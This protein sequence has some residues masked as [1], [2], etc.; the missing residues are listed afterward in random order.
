[1]CGFTHVPAGTGRVWVQRQR[2]RFRHYFST[3]RS[4][5]SEKAGKLWAYNGVWYRAPSGVQG[6]SLCQ[7]V[8]GEA[9]WSWKL[10]GFWSSNVCSKICLIRLT[11]EDSINQMYDRPNLTTMAWTISDICEYKYRWLYVLWTDVVLLMKDTSV[12]WSW[13]WG[14]NIT[15]SII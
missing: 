11:V 15:A 4:G 3:Q 14:F 1:V 2:V 8:R 12:S 7:G 6:Q 10:F 9:P 13:S 5:E